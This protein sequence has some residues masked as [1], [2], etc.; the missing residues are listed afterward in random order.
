MRVFQEE[1]RF[2]QTWLIIIMAISILVPIG[3]IIREFTQ[4]DTNMTTIEFVSTLLLMLVF[5]TAIFFFKLKTRIDEKGIHYRFFPFHGKFRTIHWS[6]IKSASIRKYDAIS[7]YGGWGLK[8]GFR[9]KKGRAFNV[10]G[11]MGIQLE[12]I[13]NKKILIGTQKEYDVKRVLETYQNK[14]EHHE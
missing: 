3:L 4:D 5:T 9:R 12:L 7:E 14:I 11:N 2:T 10:S 8:G 6:E 1:Q 13:T